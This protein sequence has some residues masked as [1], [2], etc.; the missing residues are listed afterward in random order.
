MIP[1]LGHFSLIIALVICVVQSGTSLWG[2]RSLDQVLM[3]S[4]T[5][6]VVGQFVFILLGFLAL[7]QAFVTDDFSVAYVAN[8]SNSLLP[9]QFKISA[10]WGAHEGS[11]LLWTLIMSGWTLAVAIFSRNLPADVRARVI[12]IMGILSLGFLLFLLITSNPFERLLPFAPK[13]GSDLNPLLQDFGLIVH[14]PLLY[15]GYVG[16]SVAFAFAIAALLSGRLDASWARWSRP[17]TNLAWAFLTV[18][19]TLGS[20]WAYYELGWGGWW[21]WDPVEN[22]SFMPWLAGTALI[23]SL[24]V[25]EKR[26]AFKSWTVLLAITTFSLSLLGAFVVRSGVLTSVHAFAVDPERGIFILSFFVLVVGGSLTLYALRVP[27]IRSRITFSGFSR[28]TCLLANNLLLIVAVSIVFLGTF[29]PLV[30]EA[31]TEGGKISIGVPY[32]N[33]L[34]VPVM[35]VLALCL[36]AANTARWKKTSLAYLGQKLAL[37]LVLSI[38]LGVLL[39]LLLGGIY[40]WQVALALVLAL[41]IIISHIKDLWFRAG[42]RVSGLARVSAGYYGM[43]IAH[44]GFAVVL[45]GVCITSHY[46]LEKDVRMAVGESLEFGEL[47]YTFE[48]TASVRGENYMATQ[49]SVLISGDGDPYWLYPEKR[50]YFSSQQTMSEAAINAGL[51]KDVYI[52]LGEEVGREIWTLRIHYKPFVR[53]TWLGGLLMSLGGLL[54][55]FDRRYQRLRGTKTNRP[56][57]LQHE[58]LLQQNVTSQTTQT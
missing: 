9:L 40:R 10:V 22:A 18:G 37:V 55:I 16:F 35:G 38:V 26:G 53:W 7:V 39:P 6:M 3:R 56:Q 47:T 24:A 25:T 43:F 49:G 42:G 17:W 33:S 41:W 44:L 51:L 2:A 32:F 1:E 15:T 14:P 21:F 52:S 4:G 19:I 58:Q 45:I 8:N 30:Y 27:L 46:S 5:S 12:G 20:W 34:F 54:A 48:G 50:R 31:A 11:F 29:Y 28:E 57:I 13:D 23:H 36:G